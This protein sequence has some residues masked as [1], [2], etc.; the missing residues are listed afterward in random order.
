MH[1]KTLGENSLDDFP[2]LG[3]TDEPLVEALIGKAET[4]GIEAD[5]MKDGRLEVADSDRVLGN[6]IA[7]VIGLSVDTRLDARSRHPHGKGVG[8]MISTVE[9]FLQFIPNVVLHHRGTSEFAT[10]DNQR[11][12]KQAALFEVGDQAGN[13]TVDLLALDGQGFVDRFA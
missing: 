13:G 10:P 2:F 4:V 1:H 7:Y 11:F 6:V 8:M 12:L 9:T 5:L 3:R